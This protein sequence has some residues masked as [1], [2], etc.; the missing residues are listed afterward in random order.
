M[1]ST[2]ATGYTPALA[3]RVRTFLTANKMSIEALASDVNYSRPTLSRY[4]SG[5]YS[6]NPTEIEKVLWD[7][8]EEHDDR[9]SFDSIA[10]LQYENVIAVSRPTGFF[11]SIDA[12]NII[13]I[14]EACQQYSRMGQIIG[15]SGTG[16]SLSVEEFAKLPNVAYVRCNA[17]MGHRDLVKAIEGALGIPKTYGSITERVEGITRFFDANEGYLLIV[18]EADKLLNKNTQ[19]KMDTLRDIYDQTKV[20]I[21]LVGEKALR[22]LIAIYLD[23]MENRIVYHYEMVGL[24][25]DEL[26]RYLEDYNVEPNAMLEL[27]KRAYA[28]KKGCFR[29]LD[30]TLINVF[31]LLQKNDSNIITLK[32]I[33]QASSWMTL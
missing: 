1:E 21:V 31:D 22:N 23:R 33:E 3:E 12:R 11:K 27:Q 2:A 8:L 26:A 7:Y 5:K 24:S 20:G 17:I 28:E 10:K 16:K 32:V 6:S 4:L 9:Q 13:G 25:A 15:N 30:I 18:D 19:T 14:C 29:L